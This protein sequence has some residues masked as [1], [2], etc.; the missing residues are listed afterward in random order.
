[1]DRAIR[2]RILEDHH[3]LAGALNNLKRVRQIAGARHARQVTLRFRVAAEDVGKVRLLFLDSVGLVRDLLAFDDADPTRHSA[4]CA[5]REHGRR[6]NL[7]AWARHD[8]QRRPRRMR[9]KIPVRSVK[10]LPYPTQIRFAVG[11]ASW[12]RLGSNC[13]VTT[14]FPDFERQCRDDD[15]CREHDDQISEPVSHGGLLLSSCYTTHRRRTPS[16]ERQSRDAFL[17]YD[18]F[19]TL[20]CLP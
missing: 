3:N 20:C 17:R 15:G 16:P 13:N 7:T 9:L 4:H 14:T 19:V 6:R 10:G 8:R 12:Y 1:M 5:E 2:T 11:G 18:Q